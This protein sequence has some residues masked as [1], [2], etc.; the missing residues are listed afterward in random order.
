MIR[1]EFTIQLSAAFVTKDL[2]TLLETE[3]L[4]PRKVRHF[5]RTRKNVSVNAQP[6][7]FQQL[8]HAGDRITLRFEETDYETPTILLGEKKAIH[9]LYE[10]EHLLVVDKPVGI[11]T[12]PNQPDEKNTLLNHAAAYL[13][14]SKT[15]PYVV[16]RLDKETSGIVLFAKNPFVLPILGKMLEKKEIKREYTAQVKGN[17]PT[18]LTVSKNIA[19]HRQDRR[20]RI[21]VEKTGQVAVTHFSRIHYN[22]RQNISTLSCILE[23]GRTHQIRVHLQSIGFPIIGD[24]LYGN[25]KTVAPRMFLHATR[26]TLTQ[27]FSKESQVIESELPF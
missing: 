16:H 24:P 9:V 4:L 12:H 7:R 18:T 22:E 5:L 13:Q 11:K 26:L 15:M 6:A 8:V 1:I 3:W 21:A 17:F 14:K 20:K 2:R 19:R 10:N 25:E 27:P 23:T